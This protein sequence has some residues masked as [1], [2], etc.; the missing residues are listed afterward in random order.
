[1]ALSVNAAEEE[2]ESGVVGVAASEFW[3]LESGVE[4]EGETDVPPASPS[5]SRSCGDDSLALRVVS[6]EV[7]KNAPPPS[8]ALCGDSAVGGFALPF[9][10]GLESGCLGPP[11]NEPSTRPLLVP[12][13]VMFK[14][15]PCGSVNTPDVF[16]V[17]ASGATEEA[18]TR[19]SANVADSWSVLLLPTFIILDSVDLRLDTGG[20]GAYSCA[21]GMGGGKNGD[22]GDGKGDDEDSLLMVTVSEGVSEK[23]GRKA[24]SAMHGWTA[25]GHRP[26]VSGAM[27]AGAICEIFGAEEGE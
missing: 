10:V 14:P 22:P 16:P 27:T 21:D 2:N 20:M 19:G 24:L 12:S 3:M 25:L 6:L 11:A 7:D 23:G 5:S 17:A 18:S 1:L 9:T 13:L 26:F 15:S 8:S 4:G